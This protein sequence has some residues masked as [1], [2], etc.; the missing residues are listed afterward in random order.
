MGAVCLGFILLL[1]ITSS[2]HCFTE[3][4][5]CHWKKQSQT[6][7][8]RSQTDTSFAKRDAAAEQTFGLPDTIRQITIVEQK[9]ARP[10]PTQCQQFCLYCCCVHLQSS[11][12][13]LHTLGSL[14]SNST[15]PIKQTIKITFL[16]FVNQSHEFGQCSAHRVWLFYR[17]AQLN[18]RQTVSAPCTRQSCA[19][20]YV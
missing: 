13:A 8:C 4:S 11:P 1:R 19:F 20:R 15:P 7:V 10:L 2:P 17:L 6:P 14:A 18:V 3:I 9:K 12:S 16:Y 5:H